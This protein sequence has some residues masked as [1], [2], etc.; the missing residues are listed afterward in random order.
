MR[1]IDCSES[2]PKFTMDAKTEDSMA[3]TVVA[4]RP[5]KTT[6]KE[7]SIVASQARK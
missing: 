6:I 3:S 7:A 4:S 1:S 5:R 2:S